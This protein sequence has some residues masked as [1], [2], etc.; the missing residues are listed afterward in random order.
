[1]AVAVGVARSRLRPLVVVL[2]AGAVAA[3]LALTGAAFPADGRVVVVAAATGVVAGIGAHRLERRVAPAVTA[4]SVLLTALGVWLAVPDAEAPV[5]VLGAVAVWGVAAWW[6]PAVA[7]PGR[8]VDWMALTAVVG[9]VAAVGSRG[10]PAA[11]AGALACWGVVLVVPVVAGIVHRVPS[12]VAVVGLQVAAVLAASRW[13]ARVDEVAD[14][15]ARSVVVLVVT[16]A[17]AAATAS[18]WGGPPADAS[19]P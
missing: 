1:V 2:L 12:P 16:G 10:R 4:S 15:I 17:L 19:T 6:L 13:A 3:S 18:W 5:V 11:I 8:V 14:G 7:E 9:W